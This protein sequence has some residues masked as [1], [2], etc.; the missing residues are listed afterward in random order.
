MKLR[1]GQVINVSGPVKYGET[2]YRVSCQGV[3]VKDYGN[4]WVLATLAVIDGDYNVTV[5]VNK[6]VIVSM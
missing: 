4:G 5:T 6:K 3:V 1:E 2:Y